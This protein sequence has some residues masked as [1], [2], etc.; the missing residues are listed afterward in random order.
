MSPNG[1]F[2]SFR[3]SEWRIGY[4]STIKGQEDQG[5]LKELGRE[6]LPYVLRSPASPGL[7]WIDKSLVRALRASQEACKAS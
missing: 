1:L 3:N 4:H 2:S 5:E 7:A 6:L